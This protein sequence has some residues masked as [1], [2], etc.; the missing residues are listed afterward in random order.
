MKIVFNIQYFTEFGQNL[1][2]L[3]NIPELGSLD[4]SQAAGMNYQ[5]NGQWRMELHLDENKTEAFEYK[6]ILKD[7]R[8]FSV[9]YEWGKYRK[10]RIREEGFFSIHIRDQWRDN[11]KEENTLYSSAFTG[12]LWNRKLK[13]SRPA[14]KKHVNHRF[15]LYAP[16]ID[17]NHQ[18]CIMG[19][20]KDLG[21]WN[22]EQAVVLDDSDYPLWKVDVFL[23]GMDKPIQYKYGILNKKTNK[24][25]GWEA[26]ENRSLEHNIS[27]IDNSLVVNTDQDYRYPEDK[28]RGAGVA[29]PVFSLRTAR[30]FGVGEFPDLKVL[31]DWAVKTNLKLVQILPINDTVAT[32]S[33]TDSYPYAAISVFA[34]HPIY[35]NLAD[36][37]T[38][39][40]KKEM[41]RFMREGI[42]LNENAVLDYVEVMKL[43]SR[44]Y[45][46][47]Y[48]QDRDR[49][50][51]DPAFKKFFMENR[52]WLEQYAAFSY[53]RDKYKT[54]DFTKWGENAIYN[55]SKIKDLVDPKNNFYDDIAV[56][57]FIQYHLHRQLNEV[58]EYA[59][60]KGVVLKGDLPIGIYRNSMDAWVAP[61][62]YHM[63]KQAGAP[64]DAYSISGQNWRFPT[65]NWEEMAKDDYAWW[66]RR[67][68]QM[69]KYFDAYRID[70]I[71]G[72]FRIWEIPW[73]SVEG[74]MGVF[75]PAIPMY[76]HEIESRG[77]WFD[78]DRFCKPY[79]RDY[80]LYELFGD[81]K[82][83]VIKNFLNHRG[84]DFFELKPEFNTQRKVVEYFDQTKSKKSSQTEKWDTIK[85]GLLT[86]IGNVLFFEEPGSNGEAFHPKI[87]FHQTYS[88]KELDDYNKN[89]LNAIYTHY[90]YHRQENFWRDQ[91]MVKLPAITK[92]S[93]MLV[94]GEDLGMVPDC[95]PGTMFDLGILRL[96]VQ[97]MPKETDNEFGHPADAPYLSVASPSIHDMST[98]RGW[99]E[100][101]KQRTQR[102]YN[103]M[104]GHFGEAPVFCEP[105]V[106]EEILVQH[107]YSPAM[108]AIFP[109]QDLV[110]IDPELRRENPTEERIN[111]PSNPNNL[112]QFRF[113]INLEDLLKEDDFNRKLAS[114]MEI[115]GRSKTF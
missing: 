9:V 1:Y 70:H 100:E 83:E 111:D 51:M 27:V 50:L 30:S 24:V 42:K 55:P 61:K 34:L 4:I 37:G 7:D 19:N 6:Y 102:F 84:D 72:F 35:L 95:V 23:E 22:P 25:T 8:N 75:N 68:V 110:A 107:L 80:M 47:L 26:G 106:V 76:R 33:W 3:G 79:I 98:V 64:P 78:Y 91:A 92:V 15:Q 93:D 38:L 63:D 109:I 56:H 115:S 18:F 87:A 20:E 54:P 10:L 36:M 77:I 104:L 52:D 39:S 46:K 21:H 59:R 108:W 2:V 99:W 48:D 32:H 60:E 82:D 96:Y 16:R 97:R 112:W 40:D 43:K 53:L 67:L 12:N 101:D 17:D 113:H 66:R 88:Y 44:F 62:L 74:L 5:D 73:E 29:I 13:K 71:L 49:F 86:L 45:K 57:Y 103:H 11:I 89:I 85:Y 65:Y 105:W 94:C 14:S 114:L 31:I 28:W 81:Y 58:V 90:F 41:D 69:A